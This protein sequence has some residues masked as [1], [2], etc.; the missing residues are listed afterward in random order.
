MPLEFSARLVFV[1][2]GAAAVSAVLVLAVRFLA[3]RKGI[4]DHPTGE[5]KIH[6][7]PVPLLGG[8]AIFFSVF[9]LAALNWNFLT[10]DIGSVKLLAVLIG[11]L[12]LM[13][14]GFFDDRRPRT[15]AFQMIA[16]TLAALVIVLVGIWPERL[17]N[18]FG[19]PFVL[20]AIIA[21]PLTFL[22]LLGMMF[23]TKLLDGLD[24]LTTG[25]TAIGAIMIMALSLTAKFYQPDVALLAAIIV[26]AHLG[27]LFFNWHPAS[28][29]L[30]EGG[31]LLAGFLLGVLAIIS[32]GK[33]ATT[34]LV[35]G[36]PVID[37]AAVLIVRA[38]RRRAL[39][40]G[41]DS[42]LHFR[43]LRSGLSQRKIVFLYYAIALGFGMTTL[44]LASWQKLITLA[45]LGALSLFIIIASMRVKA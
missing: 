15:A 5:R 23:T 24:G 26:G 27:F 39:Y 32:G 11:G 21:A 17:T 3:R 35:M 36:L 2:A 7:K 22:W 16:P 40:Q 37:V 43:L 1:L 13:I 30:G 33:I 18:P 14:G 20:T 41:D 45:V 31:S 19:A 38:V 4:V 28:I 44:F 6:S 34:L 42:H 25:I 12:I 29:F 10:A 9:L 8:I